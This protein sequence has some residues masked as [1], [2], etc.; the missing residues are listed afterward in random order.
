[1]SKSIGDK[2]AASLRQAKGG[3][4]K[5]TDNKGPGQKASHA[6]PKTHKPVAKK[7]A[8][9]SDPSPPPNSDLPGQNL[10]PERIWPD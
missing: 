9:K 4:A 10:H 7:V 6:A 1:M 2:L 8:R 5:R 3:A